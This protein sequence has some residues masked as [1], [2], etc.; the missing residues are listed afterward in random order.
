MTETPQQRADRLLAADQRRRRPY[1]QRHTRLHPVLWH[2]Y[3]INAYPHGF[4]GA[5]GGIDP[6]P[7][8]EAYAMVIDAQG[9]ACHRVIDIDCPTLEAAMEACWAHYGSLH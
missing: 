8:W 2:A 9:H 1:V 6:A 5:A 7:V 3:R 4:H